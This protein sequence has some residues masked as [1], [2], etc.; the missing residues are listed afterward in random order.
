VVQNALL[1]ELVLFL[2]RPLHQRGEGSVYLHHYFACVQ[3]PV[4]QFGQA[5]FI[6]Y[7]EPTEAVV[8]ELGKRV[9]V[10]DYFAEV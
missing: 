9:V 1:P 3:R 2:L 7:S 6:Q 8:A 4:L 10:A 5:V